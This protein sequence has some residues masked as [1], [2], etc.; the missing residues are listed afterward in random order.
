MKYSEDAPA[1]NYM[2]FGPA[3]LDWIVDRIN[4]QEDTGAAPGEGGGGGSEP[5]APHYETCAALPLHG[6]INGSP[7][8]RL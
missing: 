7:S 5:L 1:R 3:L 4:F 6:Q 2:L 8:S